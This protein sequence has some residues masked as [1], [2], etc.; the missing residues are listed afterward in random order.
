MYA[1]FRFAVVVLTLVVLVTS[2]EDLSWSSDR[3]HGPNPGVTIIRS[4][5][6]WRSL[7]TPSQTVTINVGVSNLRGDAPAHDVV[8]IVALSAG[9]VLKQ[10]RPAPTT[11]ETAKD[12][13]RL[14]W[15]LGAI[16]AGAFPRMFDLDL[17]ADAGLKRGT[18]LAVGASVST[19][20]KVV[21]E[22]NLR[23]A[24]VFSVENA[25]A[26]LIVDSNLDAAAFTADAPVD[27]TARVSNFGT[28]SASGC[29]LKMTVPNRSTFQSSDPPPSSQSG[30]V[31][32]W[33]LGDLAAADVRP[34]KVKVVLDPILRSTAYGFG[35]KLGGLKFTFDATT[36]THQFNPARGHLEV[37]RFPE[38]AGSNVSVSLSVVGA[39]HPGE[40][41][42]GKD[43]TYR[44]RYGNFG[45]EPA[46]QVSLSMT[47]PNGLTLLDAQPPATS[48]KK[49]DK[50][51]STVS[52]WDIGD[53][54]VGRA[55][56]I[57]TKVHVVSVGADGTLVSARIS[58]QGNDVSS[59]DKTA[60]SRCYAAKR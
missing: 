2:G 42:V 27:F 37:A 32:T 31:V 26:D 50:S 24:F 11:T 10:S 16:E 12:G 47:L 43:V 59:R 13:I 14:T 38:P 6:D 34:V 44:I 9:L 15:N 28:A 39:G 7:I 4:G 40:L 8:L 5:P 1:H 41:P 49:D 58:A 35:P 60:Y 57:K 17:Q 55:A 56:V 29:I 18:E 53:L 51:G 48:S 54:A 20:D 3:D 22:T 21:A 52:L 46:S 45:N 25:A 36:T 23:S 33:Q 19:S 30:N